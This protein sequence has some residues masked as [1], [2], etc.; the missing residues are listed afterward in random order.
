MRRSKCTSTQGGWAAIEVLIAIVVVLLMG[1]SSISII[2]DGQRDLAIERSKNDVMSLRNSIVAIY[3]SRASYTGL[4]N[5]VLEDFDAVPSG[6]KSFTGPA[7]SDLTITDDPGDDRYF[8]FMFDN[9]DNR[10]DA[11]RLCISLIPELHSVWDSYIV[12]AQSFAP[13]DF[14]DASAACHNTMRFGLRGK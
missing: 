12:G 10:E 9:F 8:R 5:E 11:T 13:G 2:G 6:F 7:G 4:K 1:V 3:S 14:Q